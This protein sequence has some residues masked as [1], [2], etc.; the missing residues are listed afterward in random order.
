[1]LKK[2][3]AVAALAVAA[4]GA[5][6]TIAPAANASDASGGDYAQ[7]VN[8]IPHACF[9]V[10]RVV[11]GDGLAGVPVDLLTE[12]KGQQCNE[13]S[14]ITSHDK[15]ALSVLIDAGAYQD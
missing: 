5:A 1:M 3:F 15:S 13:K 8:L 7:N 9:D 2:A 14:K 4:T 6:C 11:Y 12:T 10:K